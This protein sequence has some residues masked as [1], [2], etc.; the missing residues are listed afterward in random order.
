MS[1]TTEEVD[2]F[3]AFDKA[4]GMDDCR[5]P[6]PEF[7]ALRARGGVVE[8]PPMGD[9]AAGMAGEAKTFI[10]VSYEA[11]SEILRDGKT[12]SSGAYRESM[13]VVMGPNILVMD[14]PEHGRYRRLIQQAFGKKAL[15]VWEEELVHPVIHRLV[16]AFA[17]RGTADLVPELTFPFPVYVIAGML[18]LPDEDLPWFHRKA[19]DL[20]SVAIDPMRG[21]RG[22]QQLGEYLTPIIEERRKNPGNDLISVLATGELDGQALDNDHVLGFL[23]LL[24]PAGAETTARSSA[25]LIFGLLSDRAQWEALADD[26]GLMIQAIE[27]GL[28]W[29]VPLTGIGRLCVE[30]TEVEGTKIPAGSH[31][32]VLIGS[33]NRDEK[34]WDDADRFD[35]HRPPR[36]HMSFAFGPHRCLGM[37]L[38]RMET[39]VCLDAL[40]DRLPNLRLDPAAEDVHISGRGFRSPRSLPVLFG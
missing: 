37:H 18:G 10:A 35:L 11:V 6:Y 34:R 23:R 39:K 33:A 20:I 4:M 38:A 15:A 12:F 25:S 22:S 28:R 29:E 40:L 17:D 21:I 16:D 31:I 3:E 36:Q 9:A 13:G 5:D 8:A 27:E 1:A 19:V 32:Q 26:R 24:L 7:A 2:P 14:E 30:D